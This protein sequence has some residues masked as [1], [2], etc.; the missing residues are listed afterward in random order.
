MID[1]ELNSRLE[2]KRID[3]FQK[4]KYILRHEVRQVV[5]WAVFW[6]MFQRE[7]VKQNC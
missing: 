5:C 4:G 6:K 2:V 7:T 3:R 1:I